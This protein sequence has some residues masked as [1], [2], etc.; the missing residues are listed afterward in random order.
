MDK[1]E[2]EVYL[3]DSIQY[4]IRYKSRRE[5]DYYQLRS[6]LKL[7]PYDLCLSEEDMKKLIN[8]TRKNKFKITI[9]ELEE[10]AW[11]YNE[12]NK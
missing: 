12:L 1:I 5:I 2:L 9:E 3:G 4:S 7:V 11:K 8:I 6:S 10:K